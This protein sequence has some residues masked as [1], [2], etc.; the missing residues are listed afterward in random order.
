MDRR[1]VITGVG[2]V[3]AAGVGADRAWEALE[4]GRSCLGPVRAFD[5]SGFDCRLGGEADG[6]DAREFVPKSYRKFIKVMARDTELAVAAAQLAVH[7][8]G[9]SSRGSAETTRLPTAAGNPALDS[10][11]TGCQIGAGLIAAELDELTGALA[12]S[13]G[14][15]GF[16]VRRWGTAEGGAGAMNNLP[17]LWMLKYLP[18]MLACHVTI[19]HG[20]EG[21]SNTITCAESSGVLSLGESSRVIERGDADACF[22]GGAESKLNPLGYLRLGLSRRASPTGDATDGGAVVRPY[23]PSARGCVPGEGGA[24]L[25]LED[26]DRARER[27]PGRVYAEVAGFGAGHSGGSIF[28]GLFDEDPGEGFV[29]TGLRRAIRAAMDDARVTPDAI[30][31]LVPGALGIPAADRGELNALREVFGPRLPEIETITITPVLGNASA[32]HGALLAAVGAMAIRRQRLPARI[33]A[34]SAAG[35]RVGAAP[36]RGARLNNILVCTPSFGGQVGAL[37]LR[38]SEEKS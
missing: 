13:R 34:G 26:G 30:D 14:E 6:L 11:R 29:D 35:I 15:S 23:D 27:G 5:A 10:D 36:A 16:D 2:V 31:A 28:P 33:H 21:P 18:N 19:I 4:A 9:L 20:A 8:A 7:D 3:S 25:M 37:V 17:P 32:G 12:T 24:I 38:R 1:V 22:S